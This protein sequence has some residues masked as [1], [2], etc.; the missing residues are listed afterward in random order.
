[1]CFAVRSL[2]GAEA[3]A[4]D[5]ARPAPAD[6]TPL[7]DSRRRGDHSATTLGICH[8]RAAP[9]PGVGARSRAEKDRRGDGARS[10]PPQQQ[11]RSSR[12]PPS[13]QTAMPNTAHTAM[14]AVRRP[15]SLT[16]GDGAV[17]EAGAETSGDGCSAGCA[18]ACAAGGGGAGSGGS[19]EGGGGRGGGEGGGLAATGGG[20]AATNE[21]MPS[22]CGGGSATTAGGGGLLLGGGGTGGGGSSAAATPG[23]GGVTGGC[24][25]GSTG[26]RGIGDGGSGDGGSGDGGG[27]GG[28]MPPNHIPRSCDHAVLA[29]GPDIAVIAGGGGGGRDGSSDPSDQLQ[30]FTV[31][32]A[33]AAIALC[34]SRVTSA[35]GVTVA[36][37]ALS[38]QPGQLSVQRATT[39]VAL[40]TPEGCWP[41]MGTKEKFCAG[42]AA[43]KLARQ[44]DAAP[45]ARGAWSTTFHWKSRQRTDDVLLLAGHTPR[46]SCVAYATPGAATV[47]GSSVQKVERS[48]GVGAAAAASVAL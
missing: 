8:V 46:G 42:A 40:P 36:A 9:P 12:K 10:S 3:A 14:S 28:I 4:G 15:R 1:M 29:G 26:D 22:A 23:G 21:L 30:L 31:T 41:A 48:S 43:L 32:F 17:S 39:A 13:A 2:R 7:S 45:T 19:G 37:L 16:L 11:R 44:R 27:G 25:G 6:A 34:T 35:S 33:R 18:N 5:V 24:G 47:G 38:A 20:D